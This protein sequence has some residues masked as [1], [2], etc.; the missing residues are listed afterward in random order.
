MKNLLILGLLFFRRGIEAQELDCSFQGEDFIQLRNAG[1]LTMRHVMN[2]LDETL[3]VELVYEG[4]GW[5][6][7]P[8]KKNGGL[9]R[10]YCSPRPARQRHQSWQVLHERRN[11]QHSPAHAHR[12]ANSD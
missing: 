1:A 5:I 8:E 3:T 11:R 12:A 9:V 2:Q 10:S 6:S 7:I 4:E